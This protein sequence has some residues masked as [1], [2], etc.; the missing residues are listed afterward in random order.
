MGEAALASSEFSGGAPPINKLSGESGRS[1]SPHALPSARFC[2][3]KVM[4]SVGPNQLIT[5]ETALNPSV[6]P[7][8]PSSSALSPV[9]PRSV[10]CLLYTS[11]AADD[12]LC[13]D[14]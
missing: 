10:T 12:L 6:V 13:V 14:L 7:S 11:D 2:S 1:E 3:P 9:S 5:H 8:L 4:R